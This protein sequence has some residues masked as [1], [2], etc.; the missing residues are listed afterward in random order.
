MNKCAS[1]VSKKLKGQTDLESLDKSS[2][3]IV[4]TD[5]AKQDAQED[6]ETV[7]SHRTPIQGGSFQFEV[8]ITGPNEREHSAGETAYKTH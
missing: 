7:V 3:R 4:D 2:E 1:P 6:D 5:D 8:E